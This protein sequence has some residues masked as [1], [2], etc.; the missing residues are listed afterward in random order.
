[1]ESTNSSSKSPSILCGSL[2][3]SNSGTPSKLPWN[4]STERHKRFNSLVILQWAVYAA[5]CIRDTSIQPSNSIGIN[6]TSSAPTVTVLLSRK[7]LNVIGSPLKETDTL[8]TNSNGNQFS[9]NEFELKRPTSTTF[10]QSTRKNNLNL[11]NRH[12]RESQFY[13]CRNC[14]V[15][16]FDRTAT[17]HNF[18]LLLAKLQ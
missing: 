18:L 2:N 5:P 1:M 11:I 7:R 8:S 13:Y 17:T 15:L 9:L 4:A 16:L 10:Y 3:G 14:I 12:Q 6:V